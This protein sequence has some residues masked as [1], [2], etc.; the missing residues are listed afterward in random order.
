LKGPEETFQ[1]R[2]QVSPGT[3]LSDSPPRARRGHVVHPGCRPDVRLGR[4]RDKI[5]IKEIWTKWDA[6]RRTTDPERQLVREI[7]L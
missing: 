4:K 6:S 5:L 2:G 7:N 3:W 1:R